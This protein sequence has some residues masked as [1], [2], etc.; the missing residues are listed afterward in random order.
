MH[1]SPPSW[2]RCSPPA[3]VIRVCRSAIRLT[4]IVAGS[5]APLIG[6]ALLRA[7]DSWTPIAIYVLF[8]GAVSLIAALTMRE[9]RGASLLTI[10]E[11]DAR[12]T[13]ALRNGMI[14]RSTVGGGR[15][16]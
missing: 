6:T 13:G 9:T 7:Y 15:V 1:R 3:C 8:A 14:G 5:W 2:R 16:L 4:A 12:Q 10:D 11:D